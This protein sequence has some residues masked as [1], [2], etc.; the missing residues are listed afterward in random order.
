MKLLLRPVELKEHN[1]PKVSIRTMLFHGFTHDVSKAHTQHHRLDALP[2]W[3][4]FYDKLSC[5][6]QMFN[7]GNRFLPN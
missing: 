5:W 6:H 7:I 2:A 4:H 3:E 1:I